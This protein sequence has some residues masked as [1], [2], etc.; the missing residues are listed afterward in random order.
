M[1]SSRTTPAL[2]PDTPP[3]GLDA[4]RLHPSV[5]DPVMDSMR[6]LS[7]TAFRH[8]EAISFASGRPYEEFFD[9]ADLHRYLDRFVAELRARG[10]P[11]QRIKRAVF[12]YGPTAGVIRDD[13]ARVLATDESIHVDPD[14]VLITH[15]CQEAILVALRGLFTSPDDVLLTVSPCYV[16][17]TGAAKVLDI[18]VE[19]VQ[20]REHGLDP[21]D[22]A[23]A[24]RRVRAA[25][26]RPVACY[27]T[28]DFANPSGH[29]L[30][31]AA[32]RRLL[33]VAETEDLLILEDNP[34]GLFGREGATFPTLKALDRSRSV[35]HLGSFAKTA[36]PGARVGYLV[37]DQPV[38]TADGTT[39]PFA[40]ELAKVK[41]MVTVNTAGVS[42]AMI[43]GL[44]AETG[45]SMR[46]ATRGLADL[47]V[48]HLEL[49]LECLAEHF[50]PAA[51]AD[52][53][54]RWN[55]PTGGFFLLLEVPF[56]ADL[57]A[58]E[59]SARDHGVAW[60]P[61]SMFY[62]GDGGTRVIRL[63]YSS[64]TR[65]EIRE[66]ITRLAHFIRAS[67]PPRPSA[68]AGAGE[69]A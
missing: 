25:G 10:V 16:G 41:S 46:A 27:V 68:S 37:A 31:P 61:M 33:R 39:R 63:G 8:P 48:G 22:V 67:T 19:P 13:V 30:P 35:I 59:R 32:R 64:L 11:E 24:A 29:S 69:A 56:E 44:L 12:Q 51:H 15:G 23:V 65:E 20:E 26:K 47:Y 43:G 21:D 53:G 55:V 40:E 5:C 52:H 18:P 14:A 2:T 38:V 1:T 17:I 28:P 3:T 49:T 36:F 42:Q 9:F 6:L 62:V 54:V 66:G 34:Y 60:A 57:A 50:P 4:S 58:L 7:E 45:Y